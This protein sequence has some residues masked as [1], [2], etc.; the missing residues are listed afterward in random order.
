M[1][2]LKFTA[3]KQSIRNNQADLAAIQRFREMNNHH[4]N[5]SY[6]NNLQTVEH[7]NEPS[8]SCELS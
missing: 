7:E 3:E 2:Y 5:Q 1:V 4:Q 8:D 6:Q